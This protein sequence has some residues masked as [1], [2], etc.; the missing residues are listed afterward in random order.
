MPVWLKEALLLDHRLLVFYERQ[1]Q[2][3]KKNE[4]DKVRFSGVSYKRSNLSTQESHPYDLITLHTK[5]SPT[6]IMNFTKILIWGIH[7]NYIR[8]PPFFL[9]SELKL[10]RLSTTN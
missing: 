5:I 6:D 4:R 10:S 7:S 2:R 8:L 1:R 9:E 3:V